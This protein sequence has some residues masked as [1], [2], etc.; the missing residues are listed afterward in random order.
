MCS[1]SRVCIVAYFLV[2]RTRLVEGTKCTLDAPGAVNKLGKPA[3][4]PGATTG[5]TSRIGMCACCVASLMCLSDTVSTVVGLLLGLV[6]VVILLGAAYIFYSQN[7]GYCIFLFFHFPVH[8]VI[9]DC[10]LKKWVEEKL[11]PTPNVFTLPESALEK[12][13]AATPGG[14]NDRIT[15]KD[16]EDA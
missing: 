2:C 16:D 1:I 9:I 4:C 15:L 6:L 5:G 7:E 11:N 3:P 10:R 12:G 13:A 8:F 14:S